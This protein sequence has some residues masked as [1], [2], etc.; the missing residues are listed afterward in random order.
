M[1]NFTQKS[2]YTD[3]WGYEFD[4]INQED[5]WTKVRQQAMKRIDRLSLEQPKKLP[6]FTKLGYEKMKIP[7]K[8]YQLI[9][10]AK[11]TKAIVNH[12]NCEE[13]WPMHNCF[14]ILNDGSKGRI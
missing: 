14:R 2:T 3:I 5:G 6:A 9:R 1:N 13:D 10:I 4:W 7:K 8:L 12:E 11:E